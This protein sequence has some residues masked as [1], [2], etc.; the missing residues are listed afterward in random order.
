MGIIKENCGAIHIFLSFWG[1]KRLFFIILFA[2]LLKRKV[3]V[4]LEPYSESP[5]GYWEDEARIVS[6]IKVFLRKLAYP[7]SNILFRVFSRGRMPC[8]LAVSEIAEDQ[9]ENANFKDKIIYPFG[10][11]INIRGVVGNGYSRSNKLHMMFSGSLIKRKGLDIAIEAVSKINKNEAKIFLDIYGP[12]D[13]S[14]Y[15]DCD[16]SE[17]QYKGLYQQGD[18]QNTISQ[19][20]ILILPSRHDGWGLVVNEAL[21]QDV[22]VIVSDRVGA[23]VL[24]ENFGAGRVFKS[25]DVQELTN[26]L[27]ALLK[28]HTKLEE[29]KE[30]CRVA[31]D[32]ITPQNGALYLKKIIDNY[33]YDIGVRPEPFWLNN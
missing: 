23:K 31:K 29:M 15:L 25:E 19:Y 18:A 11:F 12:G 27:L 7:F 26:V 24:V 9:L 20:D 32:L 33:F 21:M 1:D 6:H 3:M 30:N 22:P 5:H 17:I 4:I 16:I 8:I 2:L 28:D 14:K 13:I 10:Y